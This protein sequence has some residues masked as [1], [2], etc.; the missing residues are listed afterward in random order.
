[1]TLTFTAEESVDRLFLAFLARNLKVNAKTKGQIMTSK[2]RRPAGM[3]DRNDP[4][5]QYRAGYQHGAYAVLK[6]LLSTTRPSL[7][8]LT[9]WTEADLQRWRHDELADPTPPPVPQ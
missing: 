2:Y 9:K 4:E 5:E 3:V 6:A 1:M 7:D 8:S